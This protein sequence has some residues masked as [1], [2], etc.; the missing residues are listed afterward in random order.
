MEKE[1]SLFL[2]RLSY[3]PKLPFFLERGES[4]KVEEERELLYFKGAKKPPASHPKRVGVVFSGGPAPGGHNV[5]WGLYEAL[6]KLHPDSQLYGFLGGPEGVIQKNYKKIEASLLEVYRNTGGFDL[7]GSGRTKIETEEQLALSLNC[8]KELALDGL[9]IIGGD[10]SNTNAA[11]LADYFSQGNVSTRVI[12]V[13]KTIDGDLKNEW[14]ETSFGFDSACKTYVELIGNLAK[15]ALSSKKYYHFIKLMGRSASH[16]ALEC[17]LQVH[18]N[19]TL[20]GEEVA[21]QNK[22]LQEISQEIAEVICKR[23]EKGKNYGLILIPEGLIEFIPE[24]KLLLRELNLLLGEATPEK[25]LEKLSASAKE[26]YLYLPEK[27]G[28]QLLLDRDSHGNVQVSHIATEELIIHTVKKELKKRADFKGKFA[29]CGHF[30]G[31]EGRAC[32]PSNFDADYC[33]TLGHVA[34]LLIEAGYTGHMG[35]VQ[36][37]AKPAEEWRIGGLPLNRLMGLE[38]RMGKQKWVVKKALVDLKAPPFQHFRLERACWEIEDDYVMQGPIQ[39][40]GPPSVT[41]KRTIT[42]ELE[43]LAISALRK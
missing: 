27:I 1:S 5:I 11:I 10:D 43:Q 32:F 9:V 14:V 39:L 21:A 7:L 25:V 12:G 16:I 26:T 33:F 37:L 18:P 34:A 24:V 41:E 28:Q 17:A 6:K 23:A 31:Y 42:L 8:V 2:E 20:I 15:D 29:P 19:I 40:F 36:N 30:F 4:F 13:P 22:T 38:E 3:R 35:F